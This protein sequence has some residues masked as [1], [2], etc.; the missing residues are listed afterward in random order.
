MNYQTHQLRL[1][2]KLATCLALIFTVRY[3]YMYVP[4]PRFT[5]QLCIVHIAISFDTG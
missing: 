3:V 1:M 2:P 5:V 4:V